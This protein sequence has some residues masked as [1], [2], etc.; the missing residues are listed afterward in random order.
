MGEEKNS[1]VN[2]I[3]EEI[4]LYNTLYLKY[5]EYGKEESIDRK[6]IRYR[7]E[8]GY[9]RSKYLGSGFNERMEKKREIHLIRS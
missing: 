5:R 4:K 2:K 3:P 7:W 8:H 6:V 1:I 9:R